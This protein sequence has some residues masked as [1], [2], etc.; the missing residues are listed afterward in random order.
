LVIS[1]DVDFPWLG[2]Q[3]LVGL[4]P[5]GKE[6]LPFRP[7][8]RYVNEEWDLWAYLRLRK[9]GDLWLGTWLRSVLQSE[10]RAIGSWKDPKPLI[11][12]GGR[13]M[14]GALRAL[15]RGGRRSS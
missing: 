4:D 12:V 6:I 10:A 8:V 5:D 7:G 9:T 1:A 13:V 3:Y 15:V 11:V 14:R 2:Y